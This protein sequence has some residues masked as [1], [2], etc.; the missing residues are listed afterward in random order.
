MLYENI[1][2]LCAEK[3][4]SVTALEKDVG[5]GHGTIRS[6]KRVSPSL[7]KVQQVAERLGVSVGQLVSLRP[8]DI[9][10]GTITVVEDGEEI[11]GC[12]FSTIGELLKR[13]PRSETAEVTIT[14]SETTGDGARGHLLSQSTAV[15]E[16]L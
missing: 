16:R 15:A 3:A 10:H 9:I 6:W 14:V 13:L 4:I 7:K 1:K 8:E 12:R 5:F 2:K 11:C